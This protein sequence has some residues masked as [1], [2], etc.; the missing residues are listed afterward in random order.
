MDTPVHGR[1][2]GIMLNRRRY[3]CRSCRKAF[4]EPVPHKDEKRQMTNR[5]IQYIEY[6]EIVTRTPNAYE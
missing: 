2:T 3:R 4:L 6:P 1:R 5:L